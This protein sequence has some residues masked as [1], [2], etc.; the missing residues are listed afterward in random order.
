MLLQNA[1]GFQAGYGMEIFFLTK[2]YVTI[3]PVKLLFIQLS[4]AKFKKF[5]RLAEQASE[6][7]NKYI[8]NNIFM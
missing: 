1:I 6:S 4:L 3:H 8:V 7:G 5:S 2:T